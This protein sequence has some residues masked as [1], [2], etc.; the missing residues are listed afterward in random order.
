MPAGERMATPAHGSLLA[1]DAMKEP[2]E[3]LL[4]HSS[5]N[6]CAG[7][8]AVRAVSFAMTTAGPFPYS[9]YGAPTVAATFASVPKKHE[10]V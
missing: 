9:A 2:N 10:R 4:R 7:R 5:C 3:R 1:R 8:Q 6:L